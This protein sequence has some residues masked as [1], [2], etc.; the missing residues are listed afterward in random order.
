MI[1]R[2]RSQ[3]QLA[4]QNDTW[5]ASIT[6]RFF[7]HI[8]ED[9][10]V[11]FQVA[12][13]ARDPGLVNVCSDPTQSVSIGGVDVPKNYVPSVTLTD[14]AVGWKAPWNADISVGVRNVFDRTPP[15]S[16]SAFS[17][18][19]FPDYDIPGRFIYARYRQRF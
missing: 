16:Y 6:G 1:W 17:N 14:I 12:R 13:A 4:W 3:L 5:S 11:P 8:V 7:D 15:V 10:S 19:F 9:C 18:S 2:W